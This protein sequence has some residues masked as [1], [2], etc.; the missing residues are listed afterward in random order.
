MEE[1]KVHIDPFKSVE[2]QIEPTLKALRP[3]IP[4]RF[5]KVRIAVKLTG[6]Q[7]GRCYEFLSGS[8]KIYKESWEPNGS[9]IGVLEMPAGM[10][11]DFLNE[12]NERTKGEVETKILK[13]TI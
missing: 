2:S 7:Y 3:L 1:A 13:G 9:W 6:D 10:R 5:D 4:I 11:D 12:L 8:G